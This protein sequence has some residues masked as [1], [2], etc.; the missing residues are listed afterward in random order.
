MGLVVNTYT[1]GSGGDYA[2]FAAY[3]AAKE[4]D[5]TTGDG[6]KDVLKV[7]AGDAGALDLTG[8]SWVT[9]ATCF[10][11]IVP[12]VDSEQFAVDDVDDPDTA[13]SS[14]PSIDAAGLAAKL[15]AVHVFAR[16]LLMISE[17]GDSDEVGVTTGVSSPAQVRDCLLVQ[18]STHANCTQGGSLQERDSQGLLLIASPLL[19]QAAVTYRQRTSTPT[20][21]A[22]MRRLSIARATRRGTTPDL[23][24]S[25]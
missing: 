15:G 14:V 21:V 1:I 9:S 19:R 8:G 22:S 11:D 6:E 10:I 16:G 17:G 3:V 2:T 13:I 4:R 7:K 24:V 18:R 5:M 20:V 12:E 25:I 23:R